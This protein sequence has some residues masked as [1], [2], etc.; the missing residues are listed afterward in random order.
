MNRFAKSSLTLAF[1]ILVEVQSYGLVAAQNAAQDYDSWSQRVLPLPDDSLRS[2]ARTQEVLEQ[3]SRLIDLRKNIGDFAPTLSTAPPNLGARQKQ[4]ADSP[5]PPQQMPGQAASPQ[6]PG[7]PRSPIGGDSRGSLQQQSNDALPNSPQ[8]FTDRGPQTAP[9]SAPERSLS[10]TPEA[11]R[12]ATPSPAANG[13]GSRLSNE[14]L[15][16]IRAELSRG[17]LQQAIGEI[18]QESRR[19]TARNQAESKKMERAPSGFEL[20]RVLEPWT[21]SLSEKGSDPLRQ[22]PKTN[23]INLPPKGQTPFRRG[24]DAIASAEANLRGE[25][26][27]RNAVVPGGA[28][29]E[30]KKEGWPA[31]MTTLA[32]KLLKQISEAP[33]PSPPEEPFKSSAQSMER[34]IEIPG[35]TFWMGMLLLISLIAGIFAFVRRL[36]PRW[37]WFPGRRVQDQFAAQRERELVRSREDL[38]RIYHDLVRREAPAFENWWSHRRANHE[39]AKVFPDHLQPL[40]LLANYYE[41]ARYAAAANSLTDSEL[42]E[43]QRAS[44]RL[45]R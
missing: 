43:A 33:Q 11:A 3:L 23:E 30:A 38:I 34:A 16:R 17:G 19:E 28:P 8:P 22:S 39:L 31:K 27:S 36:F 9:G 37:E 21:E 1:W 10:P 32:E 6:K 4:P 41:R 14:S 42:E 24:S 40:G 7:V 25:S 18:L 20:S 44:E 5:L 13:P 15:E 29:A 12:S 2:A 45:P 26:P 35:A